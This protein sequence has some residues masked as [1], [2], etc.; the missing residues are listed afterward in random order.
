MTMREKVKRAQQRLIARRAI[1]ALTTSV[2]SIKADDECTNKSEVVRKQFEDCGAWLRKSYAEVA[3]GDEADDEDHE[4]EID[5]DEGDGDADPDKGRGDTTFR[6]LGDKKEK[7][8]D[9]QKIVKDHGFETVVKMVAEDSDARGL[10]EA[11]LTALATEHAQKAYPNLSADRAFAR[12]HSESLDL[13]KALTVAK[14]AP[15]NIMPSFVGGQE[16]RDVDNPKS[17]LNQLNRLVAEQRERFPQMSE[18]QVFARV[19]ANNPELAKRE[20]EENTPRG[21]P[22]YR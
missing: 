13:R 14:L 6:G 19:Y 7:A 16:A 8:M 9:W 10:G 2:E 3:R 5:E 21:H 1:D 20:R 4:N 15:A 18:A 22:S 11:E 12:L 17:A